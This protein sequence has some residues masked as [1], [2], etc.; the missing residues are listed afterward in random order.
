MMREYIVERERALER[1]TLGSELKQ[2]ALEWITWA[3]E[4][5]DRIDPLKKGFEVTQPRE[6]DTLWSD[7]ASDET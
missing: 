3:K 5:V 4:Y 7:Q 6:S 1:T 2:E